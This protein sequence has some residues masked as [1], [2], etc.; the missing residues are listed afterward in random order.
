MLECANSCV[1]REWPSQALGHSCSSGDETSCRTHGG[2]CWV[3]PTPSRQ[4]R[5]RTRPGR[6]GAWWRLLSYCRHRPNTP[7]SGSDGA[8]IR[9]PAA[10]TPPHP[11]PPRPPAGATGQSPRAGQD[12]RTPRSKRRTAY[13]VRACLLQ[14]AHQFALLSYNCSWVRILIRDQFDL[15]GEQIYSIS[16]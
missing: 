15:R 16:R 5:P 6:G 3:P 8:F 11:S 12:G 4:P 14:I 1:A 10:R 7:G 2:S 13:A 9:R